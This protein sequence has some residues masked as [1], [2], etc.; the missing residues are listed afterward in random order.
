VCENNV[1]AHLDNIKD[2]VE[3]VK[4][5]LSDNGVFVIEAQYLLDT[6]LGNTF[7]NI[8]HEHF[9][10]YSVTSLNT[11]FKLN[12]MRIIDVKKVEGHG[13]SIRVYVQKSV[14]KMKV[15]SSVQNFINNEIKE[16]L[17]SFTTYKIFALRIKAKRVKIR[18]LVLQIKKEGKNIIGYGAPAKATTSLNFYGLDNKH[19]DYVV[20]DNPLKVG[21]VI[22]GTK[23]PIVKTISFDKNAP[24]YI[25]ILA[26]NYAKEIIDKIRLLKHSKIKFIIP[27]EEIEV[28]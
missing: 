5:I 18:E 27:A 26:W 19:I 28:I 22:P 17:H 12:D 20:E 21:K 11:F 15:K 14:G 23:I 25:Y 6:I 8:Y 13:G 2:F 10:Y 3:N 1:F 16:K 7:D 24:D 4:L 9:S